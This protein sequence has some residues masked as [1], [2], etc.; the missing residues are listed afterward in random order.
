MICRNGKTYMHSP[1]VPDRL[2]SS[3]NLNIEGN[4]GYLPECKIMGDAAENSP[5]PQELVEI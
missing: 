4:E 2:L 1:K 3:R 5:P